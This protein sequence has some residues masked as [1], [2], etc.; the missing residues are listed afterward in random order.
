MQNRSP[1]QQPDGR[2]IAAEIVRRAGLLTGDAEAGARIIALSDPPTPLERLQLLAASLQGVPVAVMRRHCMTV[3][4]WVGRY[5]M[6][7]TDQ[8]Q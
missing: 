8:D 2:D 6:A 1:K 3:E 5:C 7:E 4:E